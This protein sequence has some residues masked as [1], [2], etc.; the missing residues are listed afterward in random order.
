M[1][2][3][4]GF[5]KRMGLTFGDLYSYFF[6]LNISNFLSHFRYTSKV[7][8]D[9]GMDPHRIYNR[10]DSVNTVFFTAIKSNPNQMLL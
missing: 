7:I 6:P 3:K 10:Q 2:P 5:I 8:N 4:H 1:A 9:T